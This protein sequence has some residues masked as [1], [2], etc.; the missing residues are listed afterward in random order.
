[1]GIDIGIDIG[2]TFTDC[3]ATDANGGVWTCK[4]PTTHFDLSVGFMNGMRELARL[5]GTSLEAFLSELTSI[6]YAT[7]IGTNAVIER[8]GPKLG[9]ITTAGF[10]DTIFLGRARS[11][12]DARHGRR[13]ARTDRF[14]RQRRDAADR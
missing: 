6:R 2:G 11:W 8:S 14:G 13:S 5:A 10:E 4:T 7:T 1:M 12:A 3:F 9:L